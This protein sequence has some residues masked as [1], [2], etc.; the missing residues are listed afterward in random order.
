VVESTARLARSLGMSTLA[1]GLNQDSQV[2]AL[3]VMGCDLGVG[4]VCGPWLEAAQWQ[5]RWAGV[6]PVAA[7]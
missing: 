4:E 6:Q 3:A 5:Q 1:E 7:G 2:L